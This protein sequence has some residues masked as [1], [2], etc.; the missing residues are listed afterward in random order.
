MAKKLE[1]LKLVASLEKLTRT[2]KVVFWGD[3]AERLSASTR[4]QPAVNLDKLNKLA[5]KNKGKILVVPGKVLSVG[6]ITH[7]V[8]IVGIAASEVAKAKIKACGAE[9][10]TLKEFVAGASKVKVASTIIVK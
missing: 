10:I 8:S 2:T 7:K 3:L 9:F 5:E 4:I 6:E 1:T